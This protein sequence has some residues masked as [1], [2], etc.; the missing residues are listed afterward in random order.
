MARSN[1]ETR[2]V[3][4]TNSPTPVTWA[5]RVWPSA[6]RYCTASVT[7]CRDR[8]FT[9]YCERI[10]ESQPVLHGFLARRISSFHVW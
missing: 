10:N 2:C 8:H 1:A 6:A 3:V 5:I 9:S 4:W 7:A